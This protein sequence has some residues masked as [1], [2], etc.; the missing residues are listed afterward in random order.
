MIFL[1]FRPPIGPLDQK[2]G[3]FEDGQLRWLN[4]DYSDLIS[5][6][7][8][9]RMTDKHS[10]PTLGMWE[11]TLN[12]AEVIICPETRFSYYPHH[13]PRRLKNGLK[14]FYCHGNWLMNMQTPWDNCLTVFAD[15]WSRTDHLWKPLALFHHCSP[16]GCSPKLLRPRKNVLKAFYGHGN[17]R[18]SVQTHREKCMTVFADGWQPTDHLWKPLALL[19]RLFHHYPHHLRSGSKCSQCGKY[20]LFWQF[21][22]AQA[23]GNHL[24]WSPSQNKKIDYPRHFS[25]ELHFALGVL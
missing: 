25:S 2:L 10:G 15:G 7:Y 8:L 20:R 24:G 11:V 14:A 18:M 17:W 9:V 1:F 3:I 12:G 19:D 6:V 23:P 5:F 22:G 13:Y 21:H 16:K 4:L